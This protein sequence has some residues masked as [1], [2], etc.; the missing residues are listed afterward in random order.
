ML[1]HGKTAR[2]RAAGL[3]RL[4]GEPT[5]A[6]ADV[7]ESTPRGTE[8]PATFSTNL[9]NPALEGWLREQLEPFCKQ[10]PDGWSIAILRAQNN[11]ILELKV[12]DSDGRAVRVLKLDGRDGA[13]EVEKILAA[14]EKITSEIF[15]RVAR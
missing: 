6:A 14:L 9:R 10:Y 8:M 3:I 12:M 11:D 4:T 5:E 15:P 2:A 7:V 1:S 13:H